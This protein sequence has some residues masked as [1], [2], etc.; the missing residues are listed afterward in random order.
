V[1]TG[2]IAAGVNLAARWLL[3][4]A[5]GY[6]LAVGLAYLAGMATAFVLARRFVFRRAAGDA[7]RQFLR[8]ALVHALALAQ[9]WLVSVGLARVVFPAIGLV[10]QSET[11]AHVIGVASPILGSYL[12]HRGFTFRGGS[13]GG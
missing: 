3:Q 2:G 7:R 5:V 9:V 1:V 6:E 8:F 13:A 12:L 4:A 11:V 10:W